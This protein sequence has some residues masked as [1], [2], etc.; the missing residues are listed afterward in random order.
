MKKMI[1]LL[2]V[3][4]MTASAVPVMAD[5]AVPSDI[6]Y[7]DNEN[8]LDKKDAEK[9]PT[10]Y[11]AG[12][13]QEDTALPEGDYVILAEEGKIGSYRLYD[14]AND[15][16]I[17]KESFEYCTIAR[18]DADSYVEL[19]NAYAVPSKDVGP[20]DI[21]RN[22]VFRA[23]IDIPSGTLKFQ[24]DDDIIFSSVEN[25][26]IGTPSYM[27]SWLLDDDTDFYYINVKPNSCI[28]KFNCDVYKNDSL[29]ADYE[30]QLH[31]SQSTDLSNVSEN[32][33]KVVTE[34]ILCVRTAVVSTSISA[35]KLQEKFISGLL[36][37]WKGLAVSEWDNKYI[38]KNYEALM[39]VSDYFKVV[40]LSTEKDE[41]LV[42]LAK[43]NGV[44]G[45]K[46]QNEMAKSLKDNLY[47]LSKADSFDDIYSITGV[48]VSCLS[49]TCINLN[50]YYPDLKFG[51]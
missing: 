28:A 36:D 49:E 7:T 24:R 12:T 50:I 51:Y 45:Y 18:I 17:Y 31:N 46:F 26:Y 9:Y 39:Y 16:D 15:E 34:D 37:K 21:S 5:G 27:S 40:K 44:P 33:K 14:K 38:E 32:L 22:G 42:T 19:V 10:A 2:T 8:I 48:I 43:G 25:F 20:L 6:K 4:I 35:D 3:A 1:S 47:T 23:G 29:I 30:P 41:S 11:K 13:Y